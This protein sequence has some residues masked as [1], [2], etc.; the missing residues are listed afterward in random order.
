MN[1]SILTVNYKTLL[2][3]GKKLPGPLSKKLTCQKKPKSQSLDQ[4]IQDYALP[5]KP[6]E[7]V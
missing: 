2:T 1:E 6:V 5:S 4:D 3:G 7:M